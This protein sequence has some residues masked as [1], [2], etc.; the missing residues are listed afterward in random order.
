MMIIVDKKN[1]EGSLKLCVEH[2]EYDCIELWK[3]EWASQFIH[4][5]PEKIRTSHGYL[6]LKKEDVNID[7]IVLNTTGILKVSY[8]TKWNPKE[9]HHN[10]S[11]NIKITNVDLTQEDRIKLSYD[12]IPSIEASFI[13][14]KHH[15]HFSSICQL[16]LYRKNNPDKYN[17]HEWTFTLKNHLHTLDVTAQS[18]L[19]LLVIMFS[20]NEYNFNYNTDL[21]IN[22]DFDT[23]DLEYLNNLIQRD[24]RDSP[25]SYLGK[26][27]QDIDIRRIE[28]EEVDGFFSNR[29]NV[30]E[31]LE[32]NI[33]DGSWK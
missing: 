3:Y 33:L 26:K 10:E 24:T 9:S 29:E 1:Q 30:R 28:T 4:N 8:I 22:G 14:D 6:Y 31:Y 15:L 2:H 27:T 19:K 25:N 20:K 16:I 5:D 7:S 32:N 23:V 13:I 17:V 21:I 18:F 11:H 12:V